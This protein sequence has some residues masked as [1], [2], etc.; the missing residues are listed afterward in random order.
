MTEV[1]GDKL[2]LLFFNIRC[3]SLLLVL[4]ECEDI[5]FQFN[6]KVSHFG[7]ISTQY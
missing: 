3:R 2:V 1:C 6:V 5:D 4:F 7:L